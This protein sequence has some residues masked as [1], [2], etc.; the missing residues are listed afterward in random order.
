MSKETEGKKKKSERKLKE[1]VAL[2]KKDKEAK[3]SRDTSGS[4]PRGYK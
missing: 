4:L 2:C 1:H 3:L